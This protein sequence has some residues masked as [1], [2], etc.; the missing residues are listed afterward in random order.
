MLRILLAVLFV[1]APLAQAETYKWVDERGVVN[2]S[3]TPPATGATPSVAQP[4][5]D[6]VSS[7][8]I[9]PQTSNAMDVYRRLD[10]NQQEWLQRQYLMAMQA[11]A[12]PAAS[13]ASDY[14]Y[15]AYGYANSRRVFRP[16]VFQPVRPIA[17]RR[18][19][20]ASL[21]RF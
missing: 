21:R 12:A 14:Y 19:P 7:Y 17:P 9:D 15:P 5:P 13:A 8:T 4:I 16:A 10:A 20:R 1:A 6:R 18:A 11:Q 2:Y 3:N